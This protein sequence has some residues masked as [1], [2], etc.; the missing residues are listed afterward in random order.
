MMKIKNIHIKAILMMVIMSLVTFS[1]SDDDDK[2]FG[3]VSSTELDAIIVE[4]Q[5]IINNVPDVFSIGDYNPSAIALI[6][7]ALDKAI[8]IQKY[9]YDQEQLEFGVSQLR[10]AINRADKMRVA[11]ALP[12]IQQENDTYIQLSDNF[13]EVLTGTFTMEMKF[14]VVDRRTKG[15]SNNLFS[16]EQP[17]P[18]RG[19]A[20][21]Y[22]SDGKIQ[23]VVGTG[24]GWPDTGDQAGAG[25]I[26][27]GEWINIAVTSNGAKQIMYINGAKVAE[28]E[29]TPVIPENPFVIGN[30]PEWTDRVCN[31]V[32][33][34]FRVWDSVLEES[35]IVANTT[36]DFNGTESGLECYFP[37]NI[38]L[39]GEF[40]DLTGKYTATLKG[41]IDWVDELPEPVVINL[42]Y[43]ALND[44]IAELEA[45]KPTIVEGTNN[46]DYPVG[47][48]AFIDDLIKQGNDKLSTAIRQSEVDDFATYIT[49]NIKTIKSMLVGDT[50]GIFI[51]RNNADAVGL[52][53][54]P[55]YT[56]QG[57]YTVEF[58]VNVKSLNGYNNAD[59]FNNGQYGV[60]V[61]GYEELT[62]E[63]VLNSGGLRN[64]TRKTD[65]S[66]WEEGPTAPAL[67][68]KPGDW[69]HIAIVHHENLNGEKVTIM[70]VDGVETGRDNIGVPAE[71]GWGEMWLGNGWGKMDG[72][73]KDFRLWDVAR[74]ASDLDADITGTEAGLNAYFP[75]DKVAGVKF[76]DV[77][78]NYQGEMRGISWN[79]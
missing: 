62:E 42:D 45:L 13:K 9:A 55:N 56:P 3:S 49:D 14:F 73:I 69:H 33:Q 32:V 12:W 48:I 64:F 51:D 50:N 23:V 71:S 31:V 57:D 72:Y 29:A 60:W 65:N 46:G 76:N 47:T 44:A 54:T 2:N 1:C 41:K 22:F 58:E 61:F 5:D 70:Y 6:Q 30:S 34:D 53:I 21:R 19:F 52:R 7:K 20:V 4:A 78:G 75:L 77:T 59:L 26:V 11:E 36:A 39:G 27:T 79:K 28:N 74:N 18:D 17:G 63:N 15:H 40:K 67:T 68:V 43:T 25:T 35:T 66:G 38:N 16:V 24:S 10:D 37:F 8:E